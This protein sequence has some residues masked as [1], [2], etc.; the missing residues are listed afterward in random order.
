MISICY[1]ACKN[2]NLNC[3]YCISSDNE[4]IDQ[5]VM[6]YKKNIDKIMR[7]SPKRIVISGGEPLLDPL[8]I[9]KLKMIKEY[10]PDVYVS[11]S[12][13]GSIEYEFGRLK[14]F[15]DCID[16]SL[17]ALD[18][19]VYMLMRGQNCV[20]IVKRN[21]LRAKSD[22]LYVRISYV[23][24][25]V[26]S[27]E[28]FDVLD[29]AQKAHVNEVRIGRF[30]GLRNAFKL[31][32]KYELEQSKID[33]LM[34]DVYENHNY[35][36]DIIPPI[37]NVTKI[38][39]GYLNIDFNG[40]YFF[41]TSEGKKY[42][43]D[44]D[45]DVEI[46]TRPYEVFKKVKLNDQF[47]NLF[48][49][50]RIRQSNLDNL[51]PRELVDE[52]YS[53]RTRI[54]Y[55]PGFRR[56]QQK[57]Q[58]FSLEKNP[59]V[60][61]RLTHSI[62]VSDVG[63]RLALRIGNELQKKGILHEKYKE[64]IIAVVENACLLHDLGN[65]PFGHF[66][67]TAIKKWWKDNWKDYIQEYNKRATNI[68]ARNITFSTSEE[69]KLLKDF[70]EFDGNPQGLRNILRICKNLDDGETKL[71]SGL[72]LSFPT[73]LSDVKYI[74]CA[75]EIRRDK[76]SSD[77]IKKAGYFQSEKNI[78]DKIYSDMGMLPEKGRFPLVY[79]ME[80]ADDIAYGLSD[81]ADAIEKKIISLECFIN[82][83]NDIWN[84][85]EYGDIEE[86]IP[87]RIYNI[88]KAP[89]NKIV[90]DFNNLL[91]TRWKAAMINDAVNEYVENIE[92]Y[93]EGKTGAIMDTITDGRAQKI[94][95]V[96]KEISR[97][98]IYRAPEAEEIEIAGYSIILGL[99]H[100]F[101]QLLKL[102]YKEFNYFVDEK[103]TPAGKGLDVEWRI[104]NRISHTC[105]ESYKQQLKELTSCVNEM[106]FENI[107]WWLRVHLIVD[108]ISGMTDDYALK[109]FQNCQG[110]DIN[111]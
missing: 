95:S 72:N 94:L 49:P 76:V 79:I 3:D 106:N 37:D 50:L 88:V 1:E 52:F 27:H 87:S 110:I 43:E 73:L 108:H 46:R 42:L 83:F 34:R 51:N 10:D 81:I 25:K 4:L 41:P 61:S 98:F 16:I 68:C 22:N 91:G 2:C 92:K 67:E 74:R 70:E 66:G 99:L 35:E 82:N 56:M 102:P 86:I 57:A 15:V 44:R 64:C 24:T 60:R 100:F 84:R 65:P 80:A 5:D 48:R 96:I 58:V 78:F 59:S 11:L 29:F 71:Q 13:N 38:E 53:D 28:L 39:N 105:V 6:Q 19:E 97:K 111:F 32:E 55:Y 103:E 14:E 26:N 40:R 109:T 9:E 85:K 77:I 104:F 93:L 45:S 7:L 90:K 31:K 89:E 33:E 8:L 47:E 69:Q 23:L 75:G 36:F 101:G 18:G 20:D 107:E 21:I 63:R 12:T 62:E 54:I 17:P 30:L